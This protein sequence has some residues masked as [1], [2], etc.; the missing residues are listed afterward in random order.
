MPKKYNKTHKKSPSSCPSD[1]DALKLIL[2]VK[3]SAKKS[4]GAKPPLFRRLCN[5]SQEFLLFIDITFINEDLCH[6]RTRYFNQKKKKIII[7]KKMEKSPPNNAMCMSVLQKIHRQIQ[8]VQN[9]HRNPSPFKNMM[10]TFTWTCGSDAPKH[11]YKFFWIRAC[12][13]G[14]VSYS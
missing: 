8:T 1:L 10:C 6:L 2:K 7:K 9:M 13:T 14:I 3:L 11:Q 5:K 4:G 12:I